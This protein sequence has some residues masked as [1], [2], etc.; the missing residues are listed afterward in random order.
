MAEPDRPARVFASMRAE[1]ARIGKVSFL[2]FAAP[3]LEFVACC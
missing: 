1:R 3:K 2:A